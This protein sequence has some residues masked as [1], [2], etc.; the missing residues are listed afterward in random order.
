MAGA[1]PPD[2][3]PLP[4][5]DL[6]GAIEEFVTGM[7]TE[8]SEADRVLATVAFIDVAGSTERASELGD[9]GWRS[10]LERFERDVRDALRLYDGTLENTAGDGVLATFDGPARAIRCA[11]HIRDEVRR[12]GRGCG[13]GCTPG[14]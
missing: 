1:G 9:S 14:R 2:H 7:R 11:W 4:E 3:W 13:A 8:A 6:L 5:E 12:S 10:A